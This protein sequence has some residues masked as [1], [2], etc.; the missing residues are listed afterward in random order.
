LLS[1]QVKI[2]KDFLFKKYEIMF[3]L[4]V[5]ALPIA[6]FAKENFRSI[7]DQTRLNCFQIFEPIWA[8]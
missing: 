7:L 2:F 4:F 5:I 1:S 8:S 3:L 6:F